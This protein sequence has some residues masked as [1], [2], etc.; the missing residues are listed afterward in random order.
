L[1]DALTR[2]DAIAQATGVLLAQGAVSDREAFGLLSAAARR[3]D[4]PVE[5]VARGLLDLV[6]ARNA[7]AHQH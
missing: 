2:R 7:D 3:A 5:D 4:R 1:T 6:S